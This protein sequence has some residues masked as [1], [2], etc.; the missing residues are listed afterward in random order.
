MV[1]LYF[2]TPQDDGDLDLWNAC[3]THCTIEHPY[4]V[5]LPQRVRCCAGVLVFYWC[6]TPA[7]AIFLSLSVSLPLVLSWSGSRVVGWNVTVERNLHHQA[8]LFIVYCQL[9][10]IAAVQP[11]NVVRRVSEC[12]SVRVLMCVLFVPRV[13]LSTYPDWLLGSRCA[14]L[15][16]VFLNDVMRAM[17]VH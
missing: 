7:T 15:H 1:Q 8:L 17:K 12:W 4:E 9:C 10:C 3:G 11:D 16:S 2:S 6:I 13:V 14:V 5:C